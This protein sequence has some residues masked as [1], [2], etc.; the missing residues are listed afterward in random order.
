MFKLGL[1]GF[2]VVDQFVILGEQNIYVIQ[3]LVIIIV[4]K[5]VIIVLLVFFEQRI[6][7]V[8]IVVGIGAG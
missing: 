3:Y 2:F 6:L 1:V 7:L 5:K 8:M 4:K